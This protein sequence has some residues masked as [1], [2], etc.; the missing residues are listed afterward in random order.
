MAATS[1]CHGASRWPPASGACVTAT[2]NCCSSASSGGASHSCASRPYSSARASSSPSSADAKTQRGQVARG[3]RSEVG[4]ADFVRVAC[5]CRSRGSRRTFSGVRRP[6]PGT[7][8]GRPACPSSPRSRAACRT[9]CRSA[10]SGTAPPRAAHAR[11]L[12]ALPS[13]ASHR[14]GCSVMAFSGQVRGAQPAL[15]AVL[16]DEAQLRPL[17]V[18]E[19]RAFGAGADAAQ[20][21]RA[22][23]GVDLR[24]PNGAPAAG[25]AMSSLRCGACASR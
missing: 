7:R 4:D 21:H 14:R 22:G 1:A 18:V 13:S 5:A 23:G 24:L 8:R 19:Q 3:R 10:R 6:R 17:G 15:H 12:R 20:A 2:L 25:S 9:A 16:L 11:A